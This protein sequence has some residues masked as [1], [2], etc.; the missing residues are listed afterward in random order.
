MKKGT[1][2]IQEKDISCS[3]ALPLKVADA[4]WGHAIPIGGF[5]AFTKRPGYQGGCIDTGLWIQPCFGDI[6]VAILFRAIIG[7]IIVLPGGAACAAASAM[8]YCHVYT[9]IPVIGLENVIRFTKAVFRGGDYMIETT[10]GAFWF[11]SP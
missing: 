10:I 6:L 9:F 11:P 5:I 3:A 2:E 1:G 8:G 7:F 4:L